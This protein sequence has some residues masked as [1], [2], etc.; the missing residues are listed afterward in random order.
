MLTIYITIGILMLLVSLIAL[1]NVDK[2]QY[3][4]LFPAN[5]MAIVFGLLFGFFISTMLPIETKEI[6]V[7]EHEL[8]SIKDNNSING[9]FFLG[10]GNINGDLIYCYYYKLSETNIKMNSVY[11]VYCEIVY[12]KD[13]PKI[14]KYETIKTDSFKNKFSLGFINRNI[15]YIIYIPEGTIKNNFNLDAE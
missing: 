6:K 7:S 11:V 14:E 2:D 13:K 3:W 5:F 9:S 10:S 4:V 15:R 12:S 1:L 8:I